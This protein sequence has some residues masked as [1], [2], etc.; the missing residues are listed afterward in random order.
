MIKLAPHLIA[1]SLRALVMVVATLPTP[2]AC[3]RPV[4]GAVCQAEVRLAGIRGDVAAFTHDF[5]AT[6]HA[7]WTVRKARATR[8]PV[9]DALRPESGLTVATR[10]ANP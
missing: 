5:P 2:Q 7:S 10:G 9:R 3:G 8:L 6:G 1:V 4:S